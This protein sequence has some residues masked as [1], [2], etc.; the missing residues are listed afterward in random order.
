[1]IKSDEA[2]VFVEEDLIL[3]IDVNVTQIKKHTKLSYAQ[4]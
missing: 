1:M 4:L 3:N 2:G